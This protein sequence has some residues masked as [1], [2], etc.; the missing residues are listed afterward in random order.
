MF[1]NPTLR[2]TYAVLT[3]TIRCGEC[4]ACL[5]EV[6]CRK[7][8]FCRDMTKYGGRGSLRQKCIRRQCLRYSRILYAEDPLSSKQHVFQEDIAAELRAVGSSLSSLTDSSLDT[9]SVDDGDDSTSAQLTTKLKSGAKESQLIRTVSK[10]STSFKDNDDQSLTHPDE[11]SLE[12]GIITGINTARTSLPTKKKPGPAKKQKSSGRVGGVKGG[13]VTK[14]KTGVQKRRP[15]KAKTK[16]RLSASDLDYE[17]ARQVLFQCPCPVQYVCMFV[18]LLGLLNLWVCMFMFTLLLFA[19]NYTCI[20]NLSLTLTVFV[21]RLPLAREIVSHSQ[22]FSWAVATS[23]RKCILHNSVK[24]WDVCLLPDHIPSIALK[25]VGYNWHSSKYVFL[26]LV[27]V[28]V[29]RPVS[30]VTAL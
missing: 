21:F 7:C 16:T 11:A 25:S 14:G 29:D 2:Y 15:S 18:F 26:P 3:Y 13:G 23:E 5:T 24:V 8:R 10:D 6:D 4:V 30:S 9:K 28:H 1:K 12:P 20:V 27:Y 17:G 22:T 19:S